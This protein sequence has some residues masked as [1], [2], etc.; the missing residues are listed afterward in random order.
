VLDILPA[1]TGSALESDAVLREV[2]M[3]DWAGGAE[4]RNYAISREIDMRNLLGLLLISLSIGM[5]AGVFLFHSW[6]HA[7]LVET[8]YKAQ[9]LQAEE[10]ALVNDQAKLT[11]EDQTLMS[12]DRIDVIAQADLGMRPPR[13]SQLL[14][15]VFRDIETTRETTLA[16]A[17]VPGA[18]AEARKPQSAF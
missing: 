4:N 16:L 13:P 6:V 11:L 7:K 18:A 3:M 2:T 10:R 9:N 1:G 15:P 14:A 5:M 17:S 12:P 8:G